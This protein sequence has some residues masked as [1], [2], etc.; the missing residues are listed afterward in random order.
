MLQFLTLHELKRAK[1][2]ALLLTLHRQ[3]PRPHNLLLTRHLP[4]LNLKHCIMA[5][6]LMDK[7]E[8]VPILIMVSVTKVLP[9]EEA[10]RETLTG[11][12]TQIVIKEIHQVVT[13]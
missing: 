9:G 6:H 7:V 3:G 12:L 5:V 10:T 8:M 2:P 4:R 13:A 1:I 11:I